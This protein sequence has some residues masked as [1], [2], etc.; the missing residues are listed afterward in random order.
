MVYVV[1]KINIIKYVLTYTLLTK[2]IGKWT[3]A[4][5][6]LLL[7]YLPQKVV[8]GQVLADF[9]TDHLKASSETV[10]KVKLG[11]FHCESKLWILKFDGSNAK[12]STGVGV[13]IVSPFVIKMTMSF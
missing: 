3:L 6:K 1:S 9:I 12:T 4:L 8:K 5:T 7:I 11:I 10:P 2:R 13:V